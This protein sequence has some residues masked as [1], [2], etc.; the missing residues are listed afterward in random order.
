MF[1]LKICKQGI[2]Y[3]FKSRLVVFGF[4][5]KYGIDYIEVFSPVAKCTTFRFMVVIS[6]NRKYHLI[7]LEVKSAFLYGEQTEEM[8]MTAPLGLNSPPNMVLKLRKAQ[9][10][11]KKLQEHGVNHWKSFFEFGFI[12]SNTYRSICISTNS[13]MEIFILVYL[14]DI[15]IFGK[16]MSKMEDGVN[17]RS[18][19]YICGKIEYTNNFVL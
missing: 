13:D 16:H 6:V 11:L 15:I 5:Q 19:K 14:D 17:K 10:G 7:Q 1:D 2:I 8:Y 3:R 18:L 4:A 12:P 9:C